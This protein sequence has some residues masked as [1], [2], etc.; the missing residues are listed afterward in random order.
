MI[1]TVLYTFYPPLLDLLLS[2][3]PEKANRKKC[4][5]NGGTDDGLSFVALAKK[6]G[7]RFTRLT[8]T[9]SVKPWRDR[10]QN[11]CLENQVA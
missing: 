5:P 4:P 2:G 11:D 7:Q 10:R 6:E 1:I 9:S 8:S 3:L